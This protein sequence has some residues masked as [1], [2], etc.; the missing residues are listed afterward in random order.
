MAK[1]TP[2]VAC[3]AQRADGSFCEATSMPGA[4]YPICFKHGAALYAFVRDR[5][6]SADRE[7]AMDAF[8]EMAHDR[9]IRQIRPLNDDRPSIIYYVQIGE[10][11][12]IGTTTNVK[13]RLAAY[14][15]NRRLLAT[16]PGH[17]TLEAERHRQFAGLLDMGREW[18]RPGAALVE[19]IN[20]LRKTQGASPIPGA[21]A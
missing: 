6:A 20:G 17:E 4:P 15:P 18:F 11:I 7:T 1:T 12:K 21:A 9:R 2:W 19:H 8:V 3:T 10:H 14:P 16:E 5:M 13:R